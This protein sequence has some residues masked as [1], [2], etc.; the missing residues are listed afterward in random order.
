[1]LTATRGA[2]LY[3]G[4]LIGPGLLL[5]P[6][7]ATG[8]AGPASIVSWLALLA[9]SAPIA[10]FALTV[11]ASLVVTSAALQTS[12]APP[13]AYVQMAGRLLALGYLGGGYYETHNWYAAAL[14]VEGVLLVA[15]VLQLTRRRPDLQVAAARMLALGVVAAAM[16]SVVRLGIGFSR[17]ADPSGLLIRAVTAIPSNNPFPKSAI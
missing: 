8:I 6:A 9:L 17:T 7:L 16:L 2:A 3:V 15:V 1:M 11:A 5:I 13:L 14:L 12:T 10:L 4:A